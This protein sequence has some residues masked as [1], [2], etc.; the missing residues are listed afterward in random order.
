VVSA[1]ASFAIAP[2]INTDEPTTVAACDDLT[3]LR[4]HRDSPFFGSRRIRAIC[5]FQLR[6]G[7]A[8]GFTER[9][10]S[11]TKGSLSNGGVLTRNLR[12][13]PRQRVVPV[14]FVCASNPM[15]QT[16]GRQAHRSVRKR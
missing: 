1:L 15:P 7:T 2:E 5:A 13:A 9:A 8:V 4:R 14:A 3:D 6:T 10:N 16:K 11:V 12:S